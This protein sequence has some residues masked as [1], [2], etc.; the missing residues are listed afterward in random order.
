MNRVV[1]VV[2]RAICG[3]A[4]FTSCSDAISKSRMASMQIPDLNPTLTLAMT[5]FL[6]LAIT[7]ILT[8]P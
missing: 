5:P 6:T 1:I 2:L 3:A 8:L 7:L 4:Q